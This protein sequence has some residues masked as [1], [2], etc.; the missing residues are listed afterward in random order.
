MTSHP[1]LIRLTERNEIGAVG[2]EGKQGQGFGLGR[3]GTRLGRTRLEMK[4][5]IGKGE[6]VM[7][8]DAG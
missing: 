7:V 3:L 4:I 5:K 6:G 1:P 8:R 2:E